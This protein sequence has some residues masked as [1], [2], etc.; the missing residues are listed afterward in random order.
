MR[1]DECGY[2]YN[3][4]TRAQVAPRIR[5]FGPRYAEA[6]AVLDDGQLRSRPAPEV[7][8]PLE[9]VCH[10]RDVLRIQLERIQLALSQ[11]T[12]EFAS[13]RREERV[14]EEGYNEQDP[15]TVVNEL[16]VAAGQLAAC[17]SSLQPDGWQRTGVYNY[18]TREVRTIE[19]IGRHT[20]HEGEHHLMDIIR[21]LG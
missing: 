7:W 10:L 14:T 6:L 19:W 17:L 5:A 1:C 16:R 13:M 2:D 3:E 8:S 9:Y 4:P 12:P 18:P 20:I 15:I 11:D 21:Q